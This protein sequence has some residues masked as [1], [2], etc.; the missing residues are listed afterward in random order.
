[1]LCLAG[2]G[3]VK[4]GG[5]QPDAVSSPAVLQFPVEHRGKLLRAENV[6]VAGQLHDPEQAG[7]RAAGKSDQHHVLC[8]EDP[9]VSGE[10]IFKIPD[11]KCAGIPVCSEP[12]DPAGDI[13]CQFREE[14]RNQY[15]FKITD[16]GYKT[17]GSATMWSFIKV[18]KWC[19]IY[20]YK[21]LIIFLLAYNRYQ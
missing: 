21:F 15:K 9:S 10:R 3:T 1:M 20:K 7:D 2:K 11:G 18:V 4:S 5:Q 6:L 16:K 12:P 8:H 13:F 17:A 19:H 14:C